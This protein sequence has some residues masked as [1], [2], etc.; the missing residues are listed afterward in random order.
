VKRDKIVLVSNGPGELQTWVRP[1]LAELQRQAP[2]LETVISLIPCQF[3]SGNEARI[4]RSFGADAVTSPAESVRAMAG[5]GDGPLS[6]RAAAIIGLGGNTRLALRLGRRLQAPVYRYS[7]VPYWHPRLRRL[8]VHAPSAER[9]ARLLGAPAARLENIGNLVADAVE[10]T[11]PA[12]MA[13]SPRLLLMA[14]S[15]DRYFKAVMPLMLEALDLVH[16]EHPELTVAWP[17]SSLLSDEALAT[18]LDGT[19]REALAAGSARREGDFAVTEGGLRIRLVPEAERYAWMK[20]ADA[21]LTIP[22]TNTL[23]LGIAGTP[24]VVLLPLNRPEIIALEGPG[25]WLSLLPV[26]GTPLKRQA[27]KLFVERL[28]YPVSLPNQFTGEELMTELKGELTPRAVADALLAT[29]RDTA[30][31]EERR[32][33]LLAEMPR[34]GA[35][36]RLVSTVLTDL[37]SEAPQ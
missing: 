15:R 8:F 17:A 13:G 19:G 35:A 12:R 21:A 18:G 7:F 16:R 27:V 11:E 10:D 29:F 32:R 26:I 31:L 6:G 9:K 4:A 30:G 2:G 1:V 22:G 33:R 28:S 14:G 25:H 23:E 24:G 5:T 37:E 3:A 20:A 34:P 36:A